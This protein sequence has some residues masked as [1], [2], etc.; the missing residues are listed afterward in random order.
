MIPRPVPMQRFKQILTPQ[1]FRW[2]AVAVVFSGLGVGLLK[3]LVDYLA[4]P[5]ALATFC[6][7]E[8]CT[9][10][11]FLSVDRW[12]FGHRYP[13][14]KRLWQYHVANAAGFA[15]WWSAA[16]LLKSGGV[17]YLLAAVLAMFCSVGFSLLSNFLWVWR[18]PAVGAAEQSRPEQFGAGP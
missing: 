4:W 16:N 2:F 14:W 8:I 10:L 1:L 17:H 15:V 7:A 9:L 11:R 12:V 5:F 18:K 6:S 13:S 3:V